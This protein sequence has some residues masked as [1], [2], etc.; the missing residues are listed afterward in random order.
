MSLSVIAFLLHSPAVSHFAFDLYM[1]FSLVPWLS[2]F[3]DVRFAACQVETQRLWRSEDIEAMTSGVVVLECHPCRRCSVY[4]DTCDVNDDNVNMFAKCQTPSST[5]KCHV[6]TSAK[7]S[8]PNAVNRP[9]RVKQRKIKKPCRI[10]KSADKCHNLSAPQCDL[11]HITFCQMMDSFCREAFFGAVFLC[12]LARMLVRG[13]LQSHGLHCAESHK[14]G[15]YRQAIS[16]ISPFCVQANCNLDGKN[17]LGGGDLFF[18]ESC[19]LE[20]LEREA[21]LWIWFHRIPA[22]TT[23][24]MAA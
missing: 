17:R 2:T 3:F 5:M 12:L 18:F 7:V 23:S 1:C 14:H 4:L 11:I 21:T 13:C 10:C 9:K 19:H 6:V 8:E 20:P 15:E 16:F 24:S 22:C